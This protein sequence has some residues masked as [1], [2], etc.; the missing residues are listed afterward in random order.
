MIILGSAD[1]GK[2]WKGTRV[3][4]C[5][6]TPYFPEA[7]NVELCRE[8]VRVALCSLPTVL[9]MSSETICVAPLG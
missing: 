3:S 2:A 9:I 5:E 1:I 6:G 8:I 7:F 4:C